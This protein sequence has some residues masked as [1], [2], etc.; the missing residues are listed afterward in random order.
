MVIRR[1]TYPQVEP[2]AAGLMTR[3][4]AVVPPA[5]PIGEAARLARHRRA[6]VVLARLGPRWGGATAEVFARALGLGLDRA[7]LASVLWEAPPVRPTVSEVAARRRLSAATPFLVVLDDTRPRGVVVRDPAAGGALPR[8][9]AAAL[10]RLDAATLHVLR[11]AGAEGAQRGWPVAAVGGFPRDLLRGG[12]AEPPRD[13]D[14]VVEGDGRALARRLAGALG[15]QV[16]EHEV[17]GTATVTLPDE[18]GPR[19]VDVATARRER[20][21]VPGALPTVE[22]APLAADLARRD[23]SV[24]ALAIHLAEAAWG[25]VLDPT[26]GLP[27]LAGGRIRILHPLSFIEDPTRIFRA[28]RFAA[29]LGFRVEP[30]TRRLLAAA[31]ALPVYDALSGERL[32]AELDAILAEPAPAA[33]LTWL[34]R[35][36]GFRLLVP[37]YRFGRRAATLVGRVEA[38]TAALPLEPAT[39][40]AL[41]LLALGDG[42]D[43]AAWA[44]W[45]ARWSA[46]A[47]LRTAAER[48]RAEAPR[49]L[50]RL[51]G[52]TRRERAYAVLRGV[53]EVV[54]AWAHVLAAGGA[55]R[56]HIVAHLGS[57]RQVRPLLSGDDVAALGVAPGPLVGRV[58]EDLKAAQVAGRVRRREDAAAWVRR[59][60]AKSSHPHPKGGGQ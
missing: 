8:S 32:L 58:L 56:R 9:A 26:G 17:F 34:G 43:A 23:F 1:T 39:R 25:A 33:I 3:A 11:T 48:A 41:Y 50:A 13:L 7:P 22:P 42:L 27:D 57:W 52:A 54:A 59:A 21:R 36:G 60:V 44:A 2:R 4:V 15:G 10:A 6:E 30:T 55:L 49:L 29:R 12:L 5:L 45:L 16:R 14:I 28:A 19:R 18:R 20:Y 38:A 35:A 31:A 47:P 24:N 46:P 53:P 40:R 51:D 37:T